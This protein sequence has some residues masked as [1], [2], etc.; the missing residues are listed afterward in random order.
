M[1][2]EGNNK[3]I[4]KL[5]E[6][7][8]LAWGIS[9]SYIVLLIMN[10][11]IGAAQI[12][13][14]VVLP[15]YLIDELITNKDTRNLLYIGG[16]IVLSNLVFSFLGKLMTRN[17]AIQNVYM[18]EKMN[19]ALGIKIMK[20][21]YSYLENPYY[22]DLKERAAFACTNQSA[23]YNLINNSA[24]LLKS[25][26]TL[27]G[28]ITVMLTLGP[29]LFIVSAVTII[30]TV[31]LL[32]R[33][34][35]YQ[36]WFFE[37]IIPVN[38]KY[39][40]YLGLGF[41]ESSIQK[42]ARLYGMEPML[43]SRVVNYTDEFMGE[44]RKYY[45]KQGKVLGMIN[46]IGN[47]QSALT[48]GYV[49]IRV[50]TGQLGRQISL[51][52]FT[53][54][55]NASI[56]F[57]TAFRSLTENIV[58]VKQML[59]YLDPFLEL[60]ELPE[61]KQEGDIPFEGDIE[62]ICFEH[63][64]FCYPGSEKEVLSDL[65]FLI[66]RGEKISIVGLNGAGKTTLIKLI[67]RLYH[68]TSGKI[69]INGKDIFT[70][71]YESYIKNIAAVFQ[72]YKLFAFSLIEN[73]TSK[74]KKTVDIHEVNEIVKEVGL[75]EKLEEL[76]NG[77]DSLYG[78]AYDENGI[79]LSGGQ[80]QKVAIA[81]ALYK[82]ASLVIM[83]EPTSALDPLAE[84]DIYQNFNKMVS[85]KTAIYISHRMSSSVFCDRILVLDG[86]RV[87]DFDSHENLMKKGESL[88]CKL[89][90]AQAENYREIAN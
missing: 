61:V 71:D 34:S 14:N 23:V 27:I 90:R 47:L 89:F 66:N 20:V 7:F 36:V 16:A 74:D 38:R 37:E 60:M 12:L 65:S 84:A 32:S 17:L 67:C 24:D 85:N 3:E 30:L 81:R 58:H 68:P 6:V 41:E 49:G 9:P 56:Q 45:K 72:D 70:Y 53:M 29:V 31:I 73:I 26:V 18:N 40:Y 69:L 2:N 76:P 4:Q 22:L 13:A 83:D 10:S 43:L 21:D 75:E 25:L 35:H 44:F 11:L 5:K 59:D 88:Y 51:G 48:Y 19:Q 82:N 28:V 78:K 50:V 55:V 54:Y 79:E 46:V 77:L 42:D 87:S 62:S 86:G 63:V 1:K 52:S 8:S 64:T 57:T 15:K 33:F 39:G 80:S